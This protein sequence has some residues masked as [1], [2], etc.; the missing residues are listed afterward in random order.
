M[1]SE[2]SVAVTWMV[3]EAGKPWTITV[4]KLTHNVRSLIGRDTCHV[5]GDWAVIGGLWP[6]VDMFIF[7]PLRDGKISR[8]FKTLLSMRLST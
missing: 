7:K 6:V 2:Y 5:T 4:D 1:L 8:L 3:P